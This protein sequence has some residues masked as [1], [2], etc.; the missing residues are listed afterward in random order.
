M[1]EFNAISRRKHRVSFLCTVHCVFMALIPCVLWAYLTS[2]CCATSATI[3]CQIKTL[4]SAPRVLQRQHKE[5]VQ[6]AHWRTAGDRLS[7]LSLTDTHTPTHTC[8]LLLAFA[9]Y[10][11]LKALKKK[12]NN[13]YKT[14]KGRDHF[15]DF[16]I[17]IFPK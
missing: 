12:C 16:K 15:S 2:A 9:P 5:Q 6:R 8:T 4:T 3:I 7:S 13:N 17:I 14:L 10:P 11:E 1:A